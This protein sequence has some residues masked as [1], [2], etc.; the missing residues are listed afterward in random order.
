MQPF[1]EWNFLLNATGVRVFTTYVKRSR[2]YFGNFFMPKLLLIAILLS[3]SLVG[4]EGKAEIPPGQR[5]IHIFISGIVQGVGFRDF[6]RTS[7]RELK[8]QGWVRNL[9]NGEV[10]L[11]AQGNE[12]AMK[13]FEAKIKKGPEGARVDKI[14]PKECSNEALP[15]FEIRSTPEK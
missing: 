6:T 3:T 9:P 11:E 10:E 1:A 14:T 13:T 8:I 12:E 15:E 2:N 5:R 4:A 7:A